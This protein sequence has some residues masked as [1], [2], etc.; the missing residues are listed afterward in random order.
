MS[1]IQKRLVIVIIVVLLAVLSIAIFLNLDRSENVVKQE[2]KPPPSLK[3][4]LL[5]GCGIDGVATE[6]KEYFI[7]KTS[8]NVDI[9]SW[10]NV[11]RNLFIYNKSIIVI[12]KD[13]D[14]KLKYLMDF[15]GIDRKIYAIDDNAIE[16]LQI[17][18]GNDYREFFK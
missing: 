18:L 12:K 9:V 4:A 7:N 14:E 6:V 17:I 2:K 13:D 5:N 10:R 8:G 3:L 11:D 1:Q 15:T 16:D